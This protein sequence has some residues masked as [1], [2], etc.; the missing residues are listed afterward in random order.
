MDGVSPD[1]H[2]C[3]S[4]TP[5][6][7]SLGIYNIETRK[8]ADAWECIY[9]H[10]GSSLQALNQK[11]NTSSVDNLSNLHT[12]LASALSLLKEACQITDGIEWSSIT[13]GGQVHKDV[14]FKIA[15]SYIV[16]D[17]DQRNHLCCQ[18]TSRNGVSKLCRHCD[19]PP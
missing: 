5:L 12:G 8:K 2:S 14:K 15:V 9:F 1:T 19:C 6:N 13:Y 18:F 3:L 7:L 17:S 16:G 4:L 11:A 10:P